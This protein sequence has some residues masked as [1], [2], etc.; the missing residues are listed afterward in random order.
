MLN[1]QREIDDFRN[2]HDEA[3][4]SPAE[5]V[6]AWGTA[7]A[8]PQQPSDPHHATYTTTSSPQSLEDIKLTGTQI[9]DLFREL[10]S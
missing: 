7:D 1:S 4:G 5:G 6:R 9:D 3:I 10:V 8:N 2:Q